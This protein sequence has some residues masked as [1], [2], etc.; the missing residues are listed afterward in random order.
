MPD[1]TPASEGTLQ[2]S[3]LAR[4]LLHTIEMEHDEDGT[5]RL[6]LEAGL[7]LAQQYGGAYPFFW[8]RRQGEAVASIG[9]RK[10]FGLSPDCPL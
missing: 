2:V 3:Q 6:A 7:A 5:E 4:H 1:Q 9:F 8:D 10:L